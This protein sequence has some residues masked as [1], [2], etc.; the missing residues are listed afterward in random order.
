MSEAEKKQT[1]PS[2]A[3]SKKKKDKI[4]PIYKP[5][6]RGR[7]FYPGI[8]R[9]VLKVMGTFAA[10]V[11]ISLIF[12]TAVGE[13][14]FALRLAIN[15]ML[16]LALWYIDYMEGAGDGET[17]VALGETTLNRREQGRPLPEKDA[18]KGYTPL[19]G[20]VVGL[21]AM[22]PFL[23]VTLFYAFCAVKQVYALQ[24]LPSWVAGLSGTEGI[25]DALAYYDR[26]I[27]LGAADILRVASRLLSIPYVNI[28]GTADAD[29]LL[30]MDRLLP[31]TM[32]LPALTYGLGYLSG[33]RRRAFIH[34][35]IASNRRRRIRKEKAARRRR[36][37]EPRELV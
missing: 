37:K 7:L 11:F 22:L 10:F 34:G 4:K 2:A 15:G 6:D 1:V 21:L 27:T 31:L 33:P 18:A 17:D 25:G 9:R 16:L 28:V 8:W 12:G 13:G 30:L 3:G 5:Y 29:R 20:F 32:L 14:A 23:L 19:R 36:A 26:E 24:T 35:S